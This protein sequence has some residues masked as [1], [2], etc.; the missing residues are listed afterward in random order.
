MFSCELREISKN[1]FLHRTPL[2]AAFVIGFIKDFWQNA[3][4]FNLTCSTSTLT[5]YRVNWDED[6]NFYDV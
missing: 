3:S 6:L 1:T 5:F 4:S 2:V